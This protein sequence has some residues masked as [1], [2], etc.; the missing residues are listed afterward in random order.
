VFPFSTDGLDYSVLWQAVGGERFK[1]MDGD[2]TTRGAN[3]V[4]NLATPQ[5][6]PPLFQTVLTDGYYGHHKYGGDE[7]PLATAVPAIR[8]GLLRYGVSTVVVAP[9]SSRAAST[10][11][12]GSRATSQRR[13]RRPQRRRTGTVPAPSEPGGGGQCLGV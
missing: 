13:A 8:A 11:G 2:A 10:C 7:P 3:G 1:L 6:E 12:S 9:Q 4:G 5:L